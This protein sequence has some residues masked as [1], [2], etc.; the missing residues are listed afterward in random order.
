MAAGEVSRFAWMG[1]HVLSTGK[2][3]VYGQLVIFALAQFGV[4]GPARTG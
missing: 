1:G 2:R 3:V 4:N